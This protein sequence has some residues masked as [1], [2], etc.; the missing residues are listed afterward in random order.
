MQLRIK[1]KQDLFY[2]AHVYKDDTSQSVADRVFRQA[3]IYPTPSN[4]EKRRL[5]A[6]LIE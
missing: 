6:D 5:L 4:K 2:N 3:S 1:F